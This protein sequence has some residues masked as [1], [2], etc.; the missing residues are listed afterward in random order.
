MGFGHAELPL[1]GG[2]GFGQVPN[3][4]ELATP[5]RFEDSQRPVLP[6][7]LCGQGTAGYCFESL[8]RPV[9]HFEDPGSG[10]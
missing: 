1:E 7:P 3:L 2:C 8:I 9:E 10:R 5:A 6:I 4:K